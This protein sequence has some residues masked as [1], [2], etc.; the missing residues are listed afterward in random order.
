[1]RFSDRDI[2]YRQGESDPYVWCLLEGQIL[3]SR[4]E[5]DG[6]V[7]TTGFLGVGEFFG[8]AFGGATEAE[9][10]AA[11]KGGV[12]V[13]RA[14]VQQFQSLLLQHPS[15]AL[16]F[17]AALGGRLR[18]LERRLEAFAFMRVEARV[19]QTLR[20]LS[21]GFATRCEHGFGQHLRLTQQELADLVGAS[22]SV[23]STILN[24]LR[25]EGVLNDCH[26]RDPWRGQ[27]L[28][29]LTRRRLNRPRF[30]GSRDAAWTVRS[31][32]RGLPVDLRAAAAGNKRSAP[33][34]ARPLRTDDRRH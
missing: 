3:V 24:R 9:D 13:W 11:A 31:V 32:G 2:I 23:V 16:E 5:A 12:L 29:R 22:R 17:A 25:D 27:K 15:A 4:L 7:V 28:H 30:L 33:G 19:A 8:H 6:S 1:L 10:N 20:E 21:G 34:S 26:V 14:P 18:R